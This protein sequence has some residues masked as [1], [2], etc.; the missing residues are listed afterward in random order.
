MTSPP[1]RLLLGQFSVA[2]AARVR[3]VVTTMRRDGGGGS[4]LNLRQAVVVSV[5]GGS[6][7]TCTITFD[8]E[9]NL[10]GVRRLKSYTPVVDELVEV[11]IRD[12]GN[13]FILGA[14]A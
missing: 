4:G 11:L 7:P 12:G 8:G 2:R 5:D 1:E 3:R 14:L 9:T 10:P 6:P 13:P